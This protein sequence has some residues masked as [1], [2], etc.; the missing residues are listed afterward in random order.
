MKYPFLIGCYGPSQCDT[1]YLLSF[2]DDAGIL[3]LVASQ[4]G[5]K[6]PSYLLCKGN[7]LYSVSECAAEEQSGVARWRI[8][9]S[10]L[11]LEQEI[12]FPEGGACH[13]MLS[14]ATGHLFV[15]N[16]DTGSDAIFSLGTDGTLS[17][18]PSLVRHIGC[19]PRHPRQTSPHAHG[20]AM[21]TSPYRMASVDLGAD[22]V[23][24][25]NIMPMGT[26]V[27]L[28]ECSRLELPKGSGPR[29]IVFSK[30]ELAYLVTELSNK[31]YKLDFHAGSGSLWN[32][33]EVSTLPSDFSGESTASAIKLSPD[34]KH[35]AVSN[36]GH[37]SIMVYDIRPDGSLCNGVWSFSEGACP[38]DIA[39]TPD[40]RYLACCCQESDRLTLFSFDGES[41]RLT[42]CGKTALPSPACVVMDVPSF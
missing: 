12:R 3:D 4:K 37:N 17:S 14:E 22:L 25:N 18:T 2:D 23:T 13:L 5:I 34:E 31:V 30:M 1:L 32:L 20:N 29:H 7:V 35:L 16:Y 38:R 27:A 19:N 28:R 36:R 21:T 41:N 39:F 8:T 26:S 11:S 10:G 40:G 15:A 9:D 42:L 33:G 24:V 6:N